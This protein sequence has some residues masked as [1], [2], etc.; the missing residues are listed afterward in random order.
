MIKKSE[1]CVSPPKKDF[2]KLITEEEFTPPKNLN[3]F[4]QILTIP[5]GQ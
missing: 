4:L 5:T 2:L 3:Y 1:N